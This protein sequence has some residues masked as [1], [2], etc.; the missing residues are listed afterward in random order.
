MDTYGII[1]WP[2]SHSLSPAMHN[3]AFSALGIKAVYGLLPVAP[4][5]LKA[6]INGIRAL[7]IKGVSVTVPHKENVMEYLDEIDDIAKEI[8]AVNTIINQDGHLFGTNTDWIGA[9]NALEDIT[10]LLNKQAVVVG[11]GGAARAIVYA[12]VKSGAK[13]AIYNRTFSKAEELAKKFGAKAISLDELPKAT[14]DILIQTTNVGL[15][16]DKSLVPKEILPRFEIVMDI[17]YIP[18]ETRLLREAREAGCKVING[19]KMLVYQ[20]VEQFRLWI[21]KAPPIELM[22]KA[23]LKMLKIGDGDEDTKN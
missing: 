10:T 18:L 6:A 23:A 8:G 19:L 11:A 4:K 1:G 22:E 3:T 21:G 5:D 9:K 7:G 20:G 15:R 2:V 14:G 12:L 16:E 13:V 17:V